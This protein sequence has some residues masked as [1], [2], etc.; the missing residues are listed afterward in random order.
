[1]PAATPCTRAR[2]RALLVPQAVNPRRKVGL[3]LDG[4]VADFVNAV[5]A[6]WARNGTIGPDYT[7]QDWT[8]WDP[9]ECLPVTEADYRRALASPD[10]WKDTPSYPGA[11]RSARMLGLNTDLHIVTSRSDCRTAREWLRRRAI[12][13]RAL[14]AMPLAAKVAYADQ[15]RLEAFFEDN[16]QAALDLASVV[17]RVYLVKRPWNAVPANALPQN[18]LRSDLSSAV[19]DYLNRETAVQREGRESL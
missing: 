17:P 2:R 16:L 1:M 8:A 12:R 3:D 4:V 9:W 10:V 15:H 5:L 18:I 19:A 6:F 7:E 13:F 14:E 11:C